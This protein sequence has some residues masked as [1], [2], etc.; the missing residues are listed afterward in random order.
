[1]AQL[2][3][4]LGLLSP[5]TAKAKFLVRAAAET[6]KG[7]DSKL[8]K[9]IGERVRIWTDE[10]PH[11]SEIKLPRH[12]ALA[13]NTKQ[14]LVG[15]CDA[16]A[17][18]LGA[19]V[20]LVSSN[21]GET[22]SHL[23]MAKSRIKPEPVNAIP[24]LELTAAEMLCN[25][26]ATV[27]KAFP[28]IDK[29]DVYYFTDSSVVMY[30]LYSG[31]SSWPVYV[32]NRVRYI[33][34]TT[35]VQHWKHVDT[36]ENPA[37]IPSRSCS[38][39]DL[40]GNR[41]WW[42]GPEFITKDINSGKSTVSGYDIAYVL[43]QP[44]GIKQEIRTSL[45]VTAENNTA[46]NVN[47]ENIVDINRFG[48]YEKL[49]STTQLVL[50]MQNLL[51]GKIDKI[52]ESLL[53]QDSEINKSSLAEVLW[54]QAVQREYFQELFELCENSKSSVSPGFK[55]IFKE[56]KIFFDKELGVLRCS[57]RMQNSDLKYSTVNPI[58]IPSKSTFTTLLIR[59]AH[60][61]L[62][63]RG[64]PQTL[65]HL[66]SEFWILKG[67][68]A[69]KSVIKN[70]FAC[71][72][73]DGPFYSL[74]SHPPLPDFR[75]RK[76]RCF[77]SIGL[78]FCG[79]F[80]VRDPVTKIN[81]KAY[82]L[83]FT[84]SSSRAVHL[85]ATQ[86]MS[87]QD[88]ILAF[89]RFIDIRGVPERI[90]SDNGSSFVRAN[91]QLGSIFGSKRV[92]NFFDQRRISWHFYTEYSPWMGGFIERLNSLFKSVCRKSFGK[93]V[94]SFDEFRSMTSYAMAIIN[95]RPLTYIYSD[96][97]DQGTIL[98]PSMLM[99]GYNLLELPHL[100]I[101]QSKDDDEMDFG[102]RYKYLE[103]LKDSFWNLYSNHYLMEL[104]ERHVKQSKEQN[105]FHEPEIDDIVLIK[106][107]KVKRRDWRIG[108]ILNKRVGRDG[109]VRECTIK[110]L[111][112][113]NKNSIIKRSPSFLVPL[114]VA[115][116]DV[117]LSDKMNKINVFGKKLKN[118]TK[119]V[120]FVNMVRIIS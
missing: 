27:R 76:A 110:T 35:D 49:M 2:Y 24:R 26:M 94:L 102:Q 51:L 100:N 101:R 28:E 59:H 118:N 103:S 78:D 97:S 60:K 85:E 115:T 105:K 107:E 106:R 41:L 3:D 52:P 87:T 54:V 12:V 98:T 117:I 82:M 38:L 4:P 29:D 25:L 11:V 22:I 75:V 119:K 17:V 120:K 37:D 95:D 42:C 83:I 23:V 116:K 15:F 19:C 21:S 104:T 43:P 96:A 8:P 63:H 92:S 77:N 64:V 40:I 61:R 50:K 109:K 62:G 91:K 36:T 39:T 90:D 114:E 68:Q 48:T 55:S 72:K 93:F 53:L 113:G 79:P 86:G 71:K 88:F 31:S 47:I 112:K 16:S 20:Y 111:S 108:R 73:V 9:D 57:T 5:Y 13:E 89:Q 7:W 70:C 10:F 1:M 46:F 99:L 66:R 56:H 33:R 32:A 30:W 84:C 74:P 81:K 34:E 58:L 6:C 65:A 69:V 80:I 45:L 67:R 14:M 18:A 44:E